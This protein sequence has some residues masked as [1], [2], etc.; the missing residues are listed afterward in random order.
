[1]KVFNLNP[2]VVNKPLAQFRHVNIR[3]SR[4]KAGIMAR[5]NNSP[6]MKSIECSGFLWNFVGRT[7]S[8]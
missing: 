6:K 7:K 1:M 3:S 5:D 2:G 4:G 8:I